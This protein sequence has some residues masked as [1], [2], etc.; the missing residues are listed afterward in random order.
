MTT[1]TD[2]TETNRK[3]VTDIMA[4]LA[5]GDNTRF[6]KAMRDDF[7]WRMMAVVPHWN[8]VYTGREAVGAFFQSVYAQYATR[9]KTV[10]H[11]IIADGDTVAVEAEGGV[12]TVR[13]EPYNN[14]Y[15]MIFDMEGGKIREVR[16]Y[17]D[18]A[19]SDARFDVAAIA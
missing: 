12:T 19:L 11:R 17:L 10:P 5:E 6:A 8:R 14:R 7:T 15:C 13:G 18:T 16:E 1:D 2:K 9:Q 4:G 3:I